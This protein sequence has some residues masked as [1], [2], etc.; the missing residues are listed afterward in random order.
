[1]LTSVEPDVFHLHTG[2]LSGPSSFSSIPGQPCK[3]GGIATEPR[4]LGEDPESPNPRRSISMQV[5]GAERWAKWKV[6]SFPNLPNPPGKSGHPLLKEAAAPRQILG[7]AVL[8]RPLQ[9][10]PLKKGTFSGSQP[11][12]SRLVGQRGCRR[13]ACHQNAW[14]LSWGVDTGLGCASEIFPS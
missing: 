4:S 7:G 6:F 2:I 14:E 5:R 8:S 10:H 11:Q 3:S 12:R 13:K 9:S 1:M